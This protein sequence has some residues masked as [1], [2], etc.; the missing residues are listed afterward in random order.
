MAEGEGSHH[1]SH[2]GASTFWNEFGV[3]LTLPE[4]NLW[5]AVLLRA[6]ADY[7]TGRKEDR[8]TAYQ[9]LFLS[10]RTSPRSFHFVSEA[11]STDP[12]HFKTCIRR[13]LK[14]TNRSAGLA[15]VFVDYVKLK[16]L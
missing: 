16:R 4:H 6:M 8:R 2:H 14:G 7:L 13:F 9:W 5:F 10:N 11:I 15:P 12:E 1:R 3:Q